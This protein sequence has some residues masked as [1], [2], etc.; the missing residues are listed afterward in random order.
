MCIPQS[1]HAALSGRLAESWGGELFPPPVP[2]D[3]VCEAA[4]R[5]D[6]GMDDFDAE[7]ELDEETGLPRSFMKMPLDLWLDS[8]RRGPS[9]VAEDSPY[10]GIIVSLH[11]CGL[12]A[13]RRLRTEEER[14][15]A[16][17]YL[18]EQEELRDEWAGVAERDPETAPGLGSGELATNRD[19]LVAWDAISLAVCMPR[20]P[21]SFDGVPSLEGPTRLE[22]YEDE[23]ADDGVGTPLLRERTLRMDPWPFAVPAV[24]LEVWG[25]VL[26]QRYTEREAMQEALAAAEPVPLRATL[27]PG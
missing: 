25:R 2:W 9:L 26:A 5:H 20:L 23:D 7:P 22:I 11:G 12:L 8:W 14:E 17:E 19:L 10:A 15:A 6:D 16:V 27:L 1:Q 24:E 18:A 21:E 3:A 4:A 13:R